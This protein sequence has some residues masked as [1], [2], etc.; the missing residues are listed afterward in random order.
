MVQLIIK[1]CVITV[2]YMTVCN[3]FVDQ[4]L[5][6]SSLGDFVMLVYKAKWSIWTN[7]SRPWGMMIWL[8]EEN[9]TKKTLTGVIL[10]IITMCLI[11]KKYCPYNIYSTSAGWH[12]NFAHIIMLKDGSLFIMGRGGM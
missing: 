5:D 9:K 3:V 4:S 12:I 8:D 11:K 1:T 6:F 10:F 7:V 2:I